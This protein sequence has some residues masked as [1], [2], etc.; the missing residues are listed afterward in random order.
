MEK[1]KR[2]RIGKNLDKAMS[3]DLDLE[4]PNKIRSN[5]KLASCWAW[6]KK[7]NDFAKE[8]VE[9]YSLNMCSGISPLGDVKL[10][11]D[12]QNPKVGKADMRNIPHPDNTFDTVISDPPG[13]LDSSKG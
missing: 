7:V 6:D 12:P 1:A 2:P 3:Q 10:D 5:C 4:M 13:R 8:R 11:L 9:G